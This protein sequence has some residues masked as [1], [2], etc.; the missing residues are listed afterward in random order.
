MAHHTCIG[1]DT[2]GHGAVLK[3]I[4]E[5]APR[6]LAAVDSAGHT[7]LHTA[8][9]F[10]RVNSLR[11][12]LEA[13]SPSLHHHHTITIRSPYHHRTIAAPSP[14]HHCTITAPHHQAV[15]RRNTTNHSVINSIAVDDRQ[16]LPSL[17]HHCAIA[18]PLPSS[19]TAGK[20]A[21]PSEVR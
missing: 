16:A 17:H 4:H 2:P 1:G 8:A 12:L 15:K 14:H 7:V 21:T 5:V 18:A 20:G 13:P 9:T 10:G 19:L 3:F 11:L 6:L